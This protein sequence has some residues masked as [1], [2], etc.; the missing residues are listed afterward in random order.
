MKDDGRTAQLVVSNDVR[1]AAVI[2]CGS[3][4]IAVAPALVQHLTAAELDRIV[5][6]EWAHVQRRDDLGNV[7]QLMVRLVAGWH[8]GVWLLDRWLRAEREIACDE[9]AVTLTGSSKVYAACLVKLASL[10]LTSRDTLPA[11]GVL[12]SGSLATRVQRILSR[13]DPATAN[14]SR[15]SVTL[16]IGLL[17]GVSLAVGSLRIVEAV[18]VLPELDGGPNAQATLAETASD[19]ALSMM[20]TAP[21][22]ITVSGVPRNAASQQ[23]VTTLRQPLPDGATPADTPTGAASEYPPAD[24]AQTPSAAAIHTEARDGETEGIETAVDVIPRNHPPPTNRRKHRTHN[25]LLPGPQPRTPASRLGSARRRA[26]SQPPDSSAASANVSLTPFEDHLC[27]FT[28]SIRAM[29]PS[30]R[31]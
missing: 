1:A 10:P 5:I 13:S 15:N 8:P 18:E 9:M 11:L 4:V 25:P 23:P 7:A 31:L 26:A 2:G 28:W 6:H 29:C 19:I 22:P 3:P 14:G 20:T 21:G 24:V 27:A 16:S 30:V 17:V 12:S